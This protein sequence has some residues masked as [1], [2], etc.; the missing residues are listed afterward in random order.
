MQRLSKEKS[1]KKVRDPSRCENSICILK[2]KK[3]SVWNPSFWMLMRKLQTQDSVFMIMTDLLAV[4]VVLNIYQVACTCD[5]KQY[6]T[7]ITVAWWTNFWAFLNPVFLCNQKLLHG[8]CSIFL[9]Y[10]SP[11]VRCNYFDFVFLKKHPRWSKVN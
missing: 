4:T 10:K 8:L 7:Y 11:S 1:V 3:L 2:K 9:L 5:Y 6:F